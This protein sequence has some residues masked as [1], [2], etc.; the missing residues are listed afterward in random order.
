MTTTQTPTPPANP[1]EQKILN[2]FEKYVV[3]SYGRT[4]LVLT[5]GDGRRVWDINGKGYLDF[6]GGIAVDC[7]GHAHPAMARA[8][9]K[10]AKQLIHV[11][12]LYYTESQGKLA[13]KLVKLMGPGKIFFCNSG[14]EANEGLYKLARIAANAKSKE[15]DERRYEIITA[16]DSFHGR[17]MAGIAATGQ[18]K[19]KKG[20]DP[21]VPGFVHVPYNDL[22]AAEK[23]ITPRTAAILIEGIQGEIGII[24][25]TA[26]YLLGLR[27]L[28]DK[29]GILLMIDAVQ[30]GFW[31]TGKFQSYEKILEGHPDAEKF[32]PDA[33]S[34]AK[35]LGGGFPIGCFWI[36]KK[37]QDSLQPGMHGTTYGGNP[38][39]CAAS[40]SVIKI[41]EK[42]NLVE[43]INTN[44]EY[45]LGKLR[46]L[47]GHNAIK[48]VLRFGFLIGIELTQEAKPVIT[49]LMEKGLIVIPSGTH[50]IR[51]LPAYNTTREEIDEAFGIISSVL[52]P[53]A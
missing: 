31:R 9:A 14:A 38:L 25:A 48:T 7:L 3:P 33:V 45:L 46:T 50:R 5:K 30:C 40:L 13:K 20:F 49:A 53:G 23:A 18:E 42:E 1:A 35:S 43:N 26:E 32:I 17:T 24:P 47:T 34:M 19:I 16:L 44:G 21:A 41:I 52:K 12:N 27:K 15:G 36:R 51:L 22:E 2:D 4:P 8:I 37:Y 28:C 11:S 39:A 6:G 10:Q 29:H